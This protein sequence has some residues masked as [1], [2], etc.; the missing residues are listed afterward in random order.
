MTGG[1]AAVLNNS[2]GPQA[3]SDAPTQEPQRNGSAN[4]NEFSMVLQQRV[5]LGAAL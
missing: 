5:F 3:T 4:V 2:S 1:P